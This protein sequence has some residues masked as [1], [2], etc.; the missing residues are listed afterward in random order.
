[1][2]DDGD[3]RVHFLIN[4]VLSATFSAVVLWGSDFVGVTEFTLGR[5]AAFTG[6]LMLITYLATRE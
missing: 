4:L 6:L 3:P 5:F 1:M 2:A